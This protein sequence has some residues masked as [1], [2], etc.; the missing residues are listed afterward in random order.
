MMRGTMAEFVWNYFIIFWL[1]VEVFHYGRA[2]RN[3]GYAVQRDRGYLA[4][5]L[6]FFIPATLLSIIV[7][8]L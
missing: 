1:G 2:Y 5:K 6:A 3:G 7:W 8:M 4:K